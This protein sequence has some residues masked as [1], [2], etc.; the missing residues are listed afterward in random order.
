MLPHLEPMLAVGR[1]ARVPDALWSFEPKLD[2][3]RALV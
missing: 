2:G 1:P 3:W